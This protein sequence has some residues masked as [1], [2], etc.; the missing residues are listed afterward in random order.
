MDKN[1]LQ[2]GKGMSAVDHVEDARKWARDL[3]ANE[4]RGGDLESAWRRL[5][6]LYG[7]PRQT[8]WSLRYRPPKRIAA[9]LYTRLR[10]A[11]LAQ[12][13]RIVKSAQHDITIMKAKGDA[14]LESLA[15]QVAD[16][17]K[18]IKRKKADIN[19]Q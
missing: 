8:F 7:V 9:D 6:R 1:S 13:E 4:Q 12:C 10:L 18:A 2:T 17:A 11:Y 19:P 14:D 15:D 5:E 3:T 16:L